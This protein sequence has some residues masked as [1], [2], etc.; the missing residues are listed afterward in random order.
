MNGEDWN[1]CEAIAA[2]YR[3]CLRTRRTDL[4]EPTVRLVA[5]GYPRALVARVV[6]G[7]AAPPRIVLL[8][9]GAA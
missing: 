5:L 1:G 4:F 3:H 2:L 8:P 9:G 6:F 7:L